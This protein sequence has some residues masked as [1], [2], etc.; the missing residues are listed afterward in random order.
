[1]RPLEGKVALVT[2]G[3]R[4]IG[5]EIALKL[6]TAG[7]AVAVNSHSSPS[8]GQEVVKNIETFGGCSQYFF[9]D[10]ADFDEVKE[11]VAR[12]EDSLGTVSILV[13]SADW[14]VAQHFERESDDDWR[15]MIEVGQLGVIHAVAA[16]FPGM[17]R[18]GYGK[19]VTIAGDSGRVGLTGGAVHSGVKA[20][21]I[22]MTKAW[23]REFAAWGVRVN[24][25]SPGPIGGT[26]GRDAWKASEFG[27]LAEVTTLLGEGT[28]SDVA[29]AVLFFVLPES[30]FIT[31]QTLSV[32]GGR[33]FPS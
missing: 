1:M 33:A 24:S 23:A 21:V 12:V 22:G 15:K 7:C 5:R 32:N 11:M 14:F 26:P 10:V 30:D 28:A 19:I 9:A 31:G 17:K 2:G 27:G 20:A 13:N 16:T 18:S 3:T 6:A 4:G 8:E 25:V 29:S